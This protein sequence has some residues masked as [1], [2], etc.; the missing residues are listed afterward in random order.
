[1]VVSLVGKTIDAQTICW[2]LPGRRQLC[3]VEGLSDKGRH[4]VPKKQ[5]CF[6]VFLVSLDGMCLCV[7]GGLERPV[8]FGSLYSLKRQY[9]FNLLFENDDCM[10]NLR[11]FILLFSHPFRINYSM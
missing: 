7:G 2:H 1:M 4:Q 10:R 8:A 3:L 9:N 6:L 11:M 5:V